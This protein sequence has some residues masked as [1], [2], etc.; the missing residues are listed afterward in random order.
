RPG[1]QHQG[2]GQGAHLTPLRRRAA[3]HPGPPRHLG[4]PRRRRPPHRAHHPAPPLRRADLNRRRN[5][6]KGAPMTT[7]AI[8][9]RPNLESLA[10]RAL[11]GAAGFW[12]AVALLGQWA[13][14]YYIA[15]FYGASA[16]TGD[17][18][19]WDRLAVLRGKSPFVPGDTAGNLAFLAHALAAGI[20]A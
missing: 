1:L 12:F 19:V 20:I 14:F 6:Q 18:H 17:F 11:S 5:P 4:R 16:A 3:A 13:F 7:A 8:A 10:N 2:P 9:P 15:A